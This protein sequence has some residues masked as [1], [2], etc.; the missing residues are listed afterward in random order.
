MLKAGTFQVGVAL[1]AVLFAVGPARGQG[2]DKKSKVDER[3]KKVLDAIPLKY[4]VDRDGDF[5]L[6]NDMGKNRSQKVFI[7]SNTIKMLKLESR[8]VWSVAHISDRPFSESRANKLLEQ[9][10]KVKMGAWAVKKARG[11]YVLL[12]RSKIPADANKMTMLVTL[13]AVTQTAD[14]MEKELT[15]DKD[16]F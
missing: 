11:K 8:E 12:F 7:N 13:Q 2:G 1:A 4:K 5:V 14:R 3:V 9:N 10:D 15:A 16:A 6:V